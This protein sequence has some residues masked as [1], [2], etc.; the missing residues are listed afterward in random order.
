MNGESKI[1]EAMVQS[2]KTIVLALAALSGSV[3]V[4]AAD[5]D[6]GEHHPNLLFI[7][8]DQYRVQ[9]MG[10]TGEDPVLTPHLD[11]LAS[12]SV[13]CVNAVSTMPLSSPYRGMLMT[14]MYPH[15]NNVQTNCNTY[16]NRFGTHL[17]EEDTTFS[18][19]LDAAGYYCGY[20]GKWHL[21]A[22]EGPLAR[23]WKT[24]EWDTYTPP[25][26][27]RH[28]FRYWCSYGCHNR[29]MDPY[30]WLNDAECSDTTFARK[31]GPEFE[32]DRAIEFILGEGTASAR[33]R[34]KP[35]A[36]FVSM[37]PPHGPYSEVPER[38]KALYRDLPVD[39]LL[40]RPNVPD[41]PRGDK[42]RANVRD[43]F[44]CVTGVDEQIGRILEALDASG[45]AP[46]TIV[47]FTADHG[48]MMGSHGLMQ[49]VVYYDESFRI[50]F[51]IRWPEVLK[52]DVDSLHLG[53]PD[54][55]PTLLG[56][57]GLSDRIPDCVEGNDFSRV[58]TGDS[59]ER[60]EFALY[61]KPG[62]DLQK[63]NARGLRTNRYTFVMSVTLNGLS[64]RLY[65][66]VMDPYQMTDLSNSRHD[67]V[68]VFS[69]KLLARLEVLKDPWLQTVKS[70]ENPD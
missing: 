15:H 7:F 41:G 42:G 28:H 61:V 1:S 6:E 47:V 36:L 21:D 40:V 50:P 52:P 37:N 43:Y 14:G 60:P 70:L 49:K 54:V 17:R 56:L 65:D 31:W 53:V 64:Y 27:R 66:N 10:F 4:F 62:E 13:V 69:D 59:D 25:G 39:S 20:I 30:Y 8:P 55:M 29:H 51:L 9:A 3:N 23:S 46:N 44:A 16:A 24:A 11:R 67:L 26:P 22:P 45:Q 12:E 2:D 63:S 68:K 19:V 35:W 48:E 34:A 57:A 5:P 38:Y 18:D 33:E 58:L 32:A